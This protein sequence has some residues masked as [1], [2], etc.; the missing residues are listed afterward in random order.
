MLKKQKS[1]T[2]IEK[3]QPLKTDSELIQM[4]ELEDMDTKSY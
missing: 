1:K 2:K 4:P 3:H